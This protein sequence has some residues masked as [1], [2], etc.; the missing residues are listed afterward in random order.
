[1]DKL[2]EMDEQLNTQSNEISKLNKAKDAA[3]D[4]IRGIK[5]KVNEIME[6]V[7]LQNS[8][9]LRNRNN[10]SILNQ[11]MNSTKQEHRSI[12][13]KLESHDLKINASNALPGKPWMLQSDTDM[14]PILTTVEIFRINDRC[15]FR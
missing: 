3:S 11:T 1:M 13:S 10:I 12:L 6:E 7:E 4:M 15:P 2:W 9:I 14:Y 5:I 8:D